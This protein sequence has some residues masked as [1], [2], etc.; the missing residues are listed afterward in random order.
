MPPPVVEQDFKAFLFDARYVPNRGVACLIKIMGGQ[1][2]YQKLR[3][4]TSYHTGRR[5][6]VYDVGVVQPEMKTS[7]VLPAGQVGYFLS[8]MKSVSEAKI[9]D[10]FFNDADIDKQSIEPFPGYDTPLSMVFSGI[11]PE[12]PEDFDDLDKALKR[13]QLSDGSVEISMESS[14]ALGSGFRCGFLGMLHMDV[15]RQRLIDEHEISVIITTPS[16]TYFA[17]NLNSEE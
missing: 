10:T 7:E 11:Y 1:L 8:N 2:D 13:L 9:G 16:I 5:Y 6:D 12:D 15:F 4:I 14:A 17:K 3:L